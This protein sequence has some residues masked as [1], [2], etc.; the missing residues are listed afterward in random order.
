MKFFSCFQRYERI[1]LLRRKWLPERLRLFTAIHNNRPIA[2]GGP[3]VKF[4]GG[5]TYP[6]HGTVTNGQWR[7]SPITYAGFR[8]ARLTFFGPNFRNLTSFQ[9][10]RPKKLFGLLAYFWL[11][12]KLVGLLDLFWPFFAE[13]GSSEGKYYYSIFDNTF[14]KFVW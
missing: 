1:I 9:V 13:V 2:Y 4:R 5:L 14:A 3:H 8:V 12:L 7:T 11:H 6:C 10:S